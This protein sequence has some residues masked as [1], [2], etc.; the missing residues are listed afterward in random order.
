MRLSSAALGAEV[1]PAA[2]GRITSLADYGG[3]QGSRFVLL[4]PATDGYTLAAGSALEAAVRCR[5]GTAMLAN[6][7]RGVTG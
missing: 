4:E 3:W 1:L 6:Q 2:G 5:V 7:L